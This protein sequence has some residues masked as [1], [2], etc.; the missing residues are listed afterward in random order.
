VTK[1]LD[2]DD[3]SSVAVLQEIFNDPNEMKALKADLAD[4]HPN[5]SFLS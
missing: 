2:R 3:A 5:F 1:E 4:I